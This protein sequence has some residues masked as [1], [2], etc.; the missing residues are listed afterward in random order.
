MRGLWGCTERHVIKKLHALV[1]LNGG[2]EV[3]QTQGV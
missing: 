2:P 1:C 3:E